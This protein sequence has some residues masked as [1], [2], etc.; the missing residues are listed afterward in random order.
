MEAGAIASAHF[1][2]EVLEEVWSQITLRRLV[3]C[4]CR[5][6]YI[7]Q[8]VVL[9]Q[10]LRPVAYELAFSILRENAS[11]TVDTVFPSFWDMTIIEYLICI[12]S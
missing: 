3:S 11:H 1:H 5:L 6:G 2:Q 9:C 12:L 4:C 7:T 10:L 8:G